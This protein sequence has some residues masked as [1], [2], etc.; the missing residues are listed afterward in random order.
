MSSPTRRVVTSLIMTWD[1]KTQ[2]LY[3]VYLT[4]LQLSLRVCK[5]EIKSCDI[6]TKRHSLIAIPLLRPFQI[7]NDREKGGGTGRTRREEGIPRSRTF[8]DIRK[9]CGEGSRYFAFVG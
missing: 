1:A 3:V 4:N 9:G 6:T 5:A 7:R 2:H 8:K